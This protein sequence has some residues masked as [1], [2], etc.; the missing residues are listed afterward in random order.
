MQ[1][2]VI[3][4]IGSLSIPAH[5]FFEIMAYTAGYRYFVYLR[6]RIGDAIA[7]DKRTWIF[8]GAAAG[9][10]IG[11]RLLGV[12][13][14]PLEILQTHD[15][16]LYIYSTKTIVG[17]LLGGLI[18]VELM[19]KVIKET[20]SSGDLITYPLILGMIVGRI[21]CFLHGT[22]ESVYGI[23]TS[24]WYGMDLGDG[25]ARHPLAL[26]EIV[27]LAVVWFFIS[28][29]ERSRSYLE[30]V[31]FQIFM[32]VYLVFRFLLEFLK[33]DMVVVAGLSSIQIACLCGLLYYHRTIL[34]LLFRRN[35]LY[36]LTLQP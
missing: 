25:I 8:I 19:K 3:I 21:G 7:Y 13:E 10:L 17:G 30:G 27:F 32:T 12:L 1:F 29:G 20:R 31:R 36:G 14:S 24:G 35:G 28:R 4:H 18:G 6:R 16:F 9:A 34:N 15:L 26:Y 23:P 22:A 2:P 5:A 33:P 11:S